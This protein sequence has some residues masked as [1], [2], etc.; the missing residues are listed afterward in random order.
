MELP[1]GDGNPSNDDDE[2]SLERGTLPMVSPNLN[3]ALCPA[4]PAGKAADVICGLRP[5]R[6]ERRR[7]PSAAL[8]ERRSR[9]GADV[10]KCAVRV[11]ADVPEPAIRSGFDVPRCARMCPN[12]PECATRATF[13]KTNPRQAPARLVAALAYDDRRPAREKRAYQQHAGDGNHAK[14]GLAGSY[15]LCEGAGAGAQDG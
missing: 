9:Q 7:M 15:P 12:L 3:N 10:P 8:R 1:C 13:C 2:G 4:R 5:A 14:C 6:T 11:R